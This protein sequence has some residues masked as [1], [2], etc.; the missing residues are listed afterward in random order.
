MISVGDT[1]L[2]K[3]M[4]FGE[5]QKSII[6]ISTNLSYPPKGIARQKLENMKIEGL[7]VARLHRI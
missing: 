3:W 6:L 5:I 4:D 7:I 2:V 1:L